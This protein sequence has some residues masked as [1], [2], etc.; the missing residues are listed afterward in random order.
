MYL[1]T[2]QKDNLWLPWDKGEGYIDKLGLT[3]INYYI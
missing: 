2:K 3:Y 1:V